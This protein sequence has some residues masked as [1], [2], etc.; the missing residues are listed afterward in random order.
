MPTGRALKQWLFGGANNPTKHALFDLDSYESNVVSDLFGED[1]YFADAGA[2]WTAQSA[3]IA[4]RVEAYTADGWSEIVFGEIGEHWASRD[5]IKISKENGGS[6]YVACSH[7]GRVTFHE[8][9]LDSKTHRKQ[10][11]AKD[12]TAK[13]LKNLN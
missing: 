10:Q 3:E 5:H 4:S 2:F 12:V 11:N 1:S 13:A 8:G 7:D 6:V 9:Y